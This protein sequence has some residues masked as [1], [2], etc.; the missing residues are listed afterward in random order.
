[1]RG[2]LRGVKSTKEKMKNI[3]R[4]IDKYA[5]KRKELKAKGDL[6]ALAKL[7]RN[8]QPNPSPSDLPTDWPNPRRLPQ[9]WRFAYHA[10]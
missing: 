2:L 5:E 8:F 4:L 10:A 6:T 7:P 3:T 9:V 1:M